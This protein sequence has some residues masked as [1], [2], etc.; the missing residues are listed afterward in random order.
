MN[1]LRALDDE[2]IFAPFFRG[3]SWAAW[4]VFLAALFALPL[5]PAQLA[6]Y[7]RH[8]GRTAPPS[9]PSH[10]A[11]LVCGRRSGK[12]FVLATIAV[13][14]AAFRDWRPH[15]Q[16]GEV[17][18]IM[19]VAADRRQ[20]RV[21]MRYCLGLLRSVPMLAQLIESETR[22]SIGLRNRVVIEVHT[23]S[24]RSTRGYALIA[25]LLDEL[26]FWPGDDSAEPD[27]EVLSALR[28]GMATIPGS[29]LLCASSPTRAAA[30]CSMRT[31]SI[32]ART[33]IRSWSGMRRRAL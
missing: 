32:S 29:M 23:A 30:R 3:E 2:K 27:Y 6:L 15:L 19:V 26:A 28:P 33:A 22:E 25:G 5:S 24:F 13:F 18:T 1:I 4:R 21:I 17:G 16:Q 9:Q 31:A 11:W 20:A 8:T 10:E 7:Q 12:S 14:L